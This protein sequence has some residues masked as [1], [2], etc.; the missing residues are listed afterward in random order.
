[1]CVWDSRS[2]YWGHEKCIINAVT[3]KLHI[4]S[5][6]KRSVCSHHCLHVINFQNVNVRCSKCND[7]TTS[8]VMPC[9]FNYMYTWANTLR[10]HLFVLL[11][12]FKSNKRFGIYV[13]HEKFLVSPLTRPRKYFRTLYLNP[14]LSIP[15]SWFNNI[16]HTVACSLSDPFQNISW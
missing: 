4:T 2:H 8:I 11:L 13:P 9:D 6:S 16:M 14:N 12:T 15:V 1:M 3:V 7:G 10:V 5:A